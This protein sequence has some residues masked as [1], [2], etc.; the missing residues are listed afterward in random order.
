MV[1]GGQGQGELTEAQ[2]AELCSAYWLY[3]SARGAGDDR[4]A[5]QMYWAWELVDDVG[6]GRLGAASIDPI[7]VL[8]ALADAAPDDDA[9]LAFLGAGPVEDY[10]KGG[11]ADSEDV[12]RA[13]RSS[14]P[15]RRS[16]AFAR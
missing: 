14:A 11:R 4:V 3:Y 5:E 16:L 10:L 1:V 2:L 7:R 12:A 9:A 8:V 15:F 13:A 6:T